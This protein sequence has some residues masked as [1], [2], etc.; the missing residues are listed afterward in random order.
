L[1][2]GR[3]TRWRRSR[4]RGWRK[5]RTASM[6]GCS[7]AGAGRLREGGVSWRTP[8]EGGAMQGGELERHPSLSDR[9]DPGH[10]R[11]SLRS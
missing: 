5:P 11:R 7:P 6:S 4:G 10:T 9:R 8:A 3:R 2:P 1:W